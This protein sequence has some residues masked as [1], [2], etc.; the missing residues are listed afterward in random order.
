[1]VLQRDAEVKIW[2]WAA[3]G[4]EISVRFNGH[5]Y[6]TRADRLGEWRV[7]LSDL[8]AGGPYEMRV[9]G[10]NAIIIKDIMIGDVWVCSGQSNMELPMSRVSWMY[11][12][13]IAASE[14]TFIR[15][16]YVPRQ[17]NLI[18]PES[19]FIGGSWQSA[20]PRTVL[21]FSAAAYFFAREL[22]DRYKIP[23]GLINA[24]LGGS[25][26][27]AWMSEAALKAFPSHYQE[28]QRF[29]DTLLIKRIMEE[30][31]AR[32]AS[33]YSRLRQNDAGYKDATTPWYSPDLNTSDWDQMKLPGYWS[34]T[35]LGPVNGV[36]WFRKKIN[37]PELLED[38][39]AKLILGRIIDAD[40]VFL[41]G[42]FV[43]TTSYQ[44]PPRRYEVPSHVLKK[45][46]NTIVVRVISNTGKGGFVPDK[47]YELVVGDVSIDLRGDWQYR[48]GAQMEPLA[49]Q[50]FIRWK[51]IGLYNAMI[52]PMLK[53]C[54]KGVIWYQGESNVARP[55]EYRDL[56][57]ALVR[58]WRKNWKMGDFPFIFA[59]LHNYGA[60]KDH[61][62][63]SNWALLR[64][65]Q[66]QTLSL[67]GTGMAV[68]IDIG[69]WNDIHPLNKKDVGKR[70]A[71]AAQKVAY[72]EEHV[73]YSGPIY[74]SMAIDGKKIILMFTNIGGG[75]VA[76]GGEGLKG[77]EVAGAEK[78]FVRAK[79][80]IKGDKVVVW[81]ARVKKPVAVRYAWADN[82][83]GANLY[84]RE[85]LPASPFRTDE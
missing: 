44:Y 67:P 66:L 15:H 4:E 54:I 11:P 52:A 72:G 9:Q 14:N 82:P 68:T 31:N 36:V 3:E 75:L 1:M 73:V 26:I 62:S 57:T 18:E 21:G 6:T 7:I 37:I 84:N 10:T 85:G 42:V 80:K 48:L 51:P 20:N 74:R 8:K 25:P 13:E 78:I 43:G 79:A 71:L 2:G 23:I 60:A 22:Y 29:K 61:P 32:I 70:L 19:D 76:R 34:D 12:S 69:E 64:E 45:G 39:E 16:F 77:F 33:W 40:S 30:D 49:G 38:N 41:N 50:T 63:E 55:K 46:E 58:D 24:G 81:S 28:A 5:D 83:Q 56:F 59:Q 27:E 17:Y 47:P 35:E 65:A 53:Y